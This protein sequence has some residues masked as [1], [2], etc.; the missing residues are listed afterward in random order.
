MYVFSEGAAASALA[1]WHIRKLSSKGIKLGGG[2]DTLALCSKTVAW[3]LETPITAHHLTH[4]C[5]PC[6][7]AYLI[8]EK[9][10]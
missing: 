3:D 5:K 6:A 2:A 8:E 7:D 4:C 9:K 1:P 10:E